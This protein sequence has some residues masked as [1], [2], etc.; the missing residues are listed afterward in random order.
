MVLSQKI[1]LSDQDAALK[2]EI[3]GALN[4]VNC[5]HS[6]TSSNG[7]GEMYKSMFPDSNIAKNYK[8]GET[9]TKYVI[10]YG[11]APH[12]Q[13]L[14]QEEYKQTPNTFKFDE[15][16]TQQVKKQ[17]DGYVQFWSRKSQCIKIM[18]CGTLMV[19]HCPAEKLLEHFLFLLTSQ[20][21]I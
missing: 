4:A 20:N 5:N 15:T 18:Y 1:I 3:L 9:K 6:F 13:K 11:I 14:L 17:Y 8:M 7:S 16:T 2:A 12:F 21:L 19:S 10:Q